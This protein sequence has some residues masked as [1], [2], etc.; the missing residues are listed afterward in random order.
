MPIESISLSYV[1]FSLDSRYSYTKLRSM[2]IT[3][4]LLKVYSLKSLEHVRELCTDQRDNLQ[5]VLSASQVL[6]RITYT[7]FNAG[8]GDFEQYAQKT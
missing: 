5:D 4:S 1:G 6:D 2:T 7:T 3:N 8:L